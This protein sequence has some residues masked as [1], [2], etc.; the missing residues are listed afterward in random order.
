MTKLRFGISMS[1]DGYVAGPNQSVEHPLGTGGER[2]HEWAI[3]LAEWRAPHGLEGGEVSE[4]S[5]VLQESTANIGATI[6]GRNMFGGHPGHGTRT[7]RG[8]AGGARIRRST[9]RCSC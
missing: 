8:T 6:M 3:R 4:S 1:I 7:S 5:R 9:T 2:L